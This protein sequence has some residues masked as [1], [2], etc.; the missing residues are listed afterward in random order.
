MHYF[1]NNYCISTFKICIS[2]FKI[3][4]AIIH[5][6][7]SIYNLLIVYH[8]FETSILKVE[9]KKHG[10]KHVKAYLLSY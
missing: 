8:S 3:C 6:T 1:Q 9:K 7:Q 4:F 5:E 2:I 10:K